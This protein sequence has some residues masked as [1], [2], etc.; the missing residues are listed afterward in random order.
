M[1]VELENNVI[2]KKI[3]S[4]NSF[5]ISSINIKPNIS[6]NLDIIFYCNDQLHSKQYLSKKIYVQIGK[7]TII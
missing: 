2:V 1:K 6:A 5:E 4:I 3:Y 7:L